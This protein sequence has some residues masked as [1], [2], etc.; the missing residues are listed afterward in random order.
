MKVTDHETVLK[1][2]N[3]K[4]KVGYSVGIQRSCLFRYCMRSLVS[5]GKSDRR[6]LRIQWSDEER[7]NSFSTPILR[8][9]DQVTWSSLPLRCS[10]KESVIF[11]LNYTLHTSP[12]RH[13]VFSRVKFVSVFVLP[14]E[15]LRSHR[16]QSWSELSV[17]K[18]GFCVCWT[19]SKWYLKLHPN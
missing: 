17:K 9:L 2:N 5:S 14:C 3:T 1:W 8:Y 4:T 16:H 19:E 12:A 15:S 11:T 18:L 10:L 6:K 13:M 7:N